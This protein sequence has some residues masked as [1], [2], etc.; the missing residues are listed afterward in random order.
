[1]K[2]LSLIMALALIVTA[3]GCGKNK[4][5]EVTVGGTSDEIVETTEPTQAPEEAVEPTAAPDA[6]VTKAPDAAK[7]PT[8]K[9]AATK[10]PTEAPAANP[11]KNPTKA[12]VATVA[13]TPIPTVGPTPA[14]TQKPTPAPTATPVPTPKPTPTPT[15][16]PAE[17]N[18]SLDE[19]MAKITS[20][21]GEMP[22]TANMPLDSENFEFYT[23]AGYVEGAEGVACEPM[24][25]SIAHS[26]V[27]VRLPAGQDAAAFASKMK[28]NADPRKWLCVE[29]EKV[30][31]ASKGNL[32][33]LVMSASDTTDKIIANFKSL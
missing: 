7:Q 28:Q 3:T 18:R 29:A 26:V 10:K 1:M 24:M 23:F 15:P 27:L 8:K 31:T 33:L 17:D 25:S 9:P 4:T 20:N 13:P 16:A 32:A 12:P 14:P 2:K 6:E 11:T 22:M 5:E 19:L 30:S 21:L